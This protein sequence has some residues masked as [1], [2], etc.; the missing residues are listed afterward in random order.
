[1][2]PSGSNANFINLFGY[3]FPRLHEGKQW[4]VDFY[5]LD[6]STNTPR[7]KKYH[8]PMT[9]PVSVRRLQAFTL[10]EKL[11]SKLRSGWTPWSVKEVFRED[12]LIDLVLE[13]FLS[14]IETTHRKSTY[15]NYCSNANILRTYISSVR[16]SDM[17]VSEFN[18]AFVNDFL[19]WLIID[20]KSSV[21]T[22]NKLRGWCSA[23][24]E[25]MI[26]RDYIPDNPVS[27]TKKMPVISKNRDA[28]SSE[29]L[30]LLWAHLHRTN[31]HF[32]LACMMEYYTFIRPNELR[33][34]RIKDI[35]V[36][37]MT[38]YVPGE[39][40]KNK[41]DAKVSLNR[42]CLQLMID[43]GVLNNPGSHYLFGKNFIPSVKQGPSDMF[44]KYWASM[45]KTLGWGEDK[46]FYSLKDSG[47]R[48]LSNAAGVV[49]ARNQARHTDISTT[50][51]Y[52]QGRDLDAPE[53][54]KHFKGELKFSQS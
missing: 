20:R 16:K 4:Y 18:H 23:F 38:I 41:R 36:K 3:T 6:P 42:E 17:Y 2:C 10:I 15:H 49:T 34:V 11:A 50:N 47:I 8:I 35:S 51:K 30:H 24:A 29:E 27:R 33:H 25:Y 7:R 32:L 12:T 37:E 53:A 1:M 5:T 46:K 26:A 54:A 31:R 28:L 39:F 13:K 19:D 52:L 14:G 40:S 21:R 22:R 44:N 48:D 9:S 45:R 43:L